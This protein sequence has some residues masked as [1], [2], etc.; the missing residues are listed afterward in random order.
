[1]SERPQPTPKELQRAVQKAAQELA[2]N[3]D[4]TDPRSTQA[5]DVLETMSTN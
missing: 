3:V 1:M 4:E 2:K 5:R